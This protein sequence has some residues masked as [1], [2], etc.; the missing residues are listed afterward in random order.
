[1]TSLLAHISN[2]FSPSSFIDENERYQAN[3]VHKLLKV[4]LTKQ[5]GDLGPAFLAA[6]VSLPNAA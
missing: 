5:V 3:C 2:F 1:M 6:F 4:A